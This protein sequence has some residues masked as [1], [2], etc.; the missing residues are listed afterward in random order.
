MKGRE[1]G[2]FLELQQL[3]EVVNEYSGWSTLLYYEGYLSEQLYISWLFAHQNLDF[4]PK[5]QH[6]QRPLSPVSWRDL[7]TTLPVATG[8]QS[9]GR[10]QNSP[11]VDERATLG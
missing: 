6:Q 10:A 5:Y 4:I 11:P 7:S 9:Q 8:P 1:G 3:A 2:L